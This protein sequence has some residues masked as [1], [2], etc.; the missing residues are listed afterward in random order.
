MAY[1]LRNSVNFFPLLMAVWIASG[2]I[3][4]GCDTYVVANNPIAVI[5]EDPRGRYCLLGI[6]IIGLLILLSYYSIVRTSWSLTA[7]LWIIVFYIL[8]VI[9][10]INWMGKE[11]CSMTRQVFLLCSFLSGMLAA[12]LCATSR[13]TLIVLVILIGIE[14]ILAIF[15]YSTGGDKF[16]SG[17]VL[18]ASGTYGH[19][20]SLYRILIAAL[21]ISISLYLASLN[22]SVRFASVALSIFVGIALLLTWY[23]TGALAGSLSSVWV[24]AKILTRRSILCMAA[25]F[26]LLIVFTTAVARTKDDVDDASSKRSVTSHLSLWRE[27]WHVFLKHPIAGIGVTSLNLPAETMFHGIPIVATLPGPHNQML[28]VLD[29]TGIL[30]CALLVGFLLL[31]SK[32]L[33]QSNSICGYGLW[34]G[35]LGLSIAGITDTVF[36]I[37]TQEYGPI[38]AVVG[39]MLGATLLSAVGVDGTSMSRT[40]TESRNWVILDRTAKT[41]D[42]RV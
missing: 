1:I 31:I 28:F 13:M 16:Y 4:S 27:G 24:I 2:F 35:W 30:G 32:V 42:R 19:P 22:R 20:S 26:C 36:G 11:Q 23:R 8:L 5:A 7:L 14:S 41:R 37:G 9:S 40:D 6:S 18:R 15:I 25:C 29:E 12:R 21:P 34:A 3:L 39:M 10:P 17:D 33:L 38:N